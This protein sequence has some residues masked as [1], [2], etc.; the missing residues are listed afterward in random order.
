M[1]RKE[2]SRGLSPAW[3]PGTQV[4]NLRY[5]TLASPIVVNKKANPFVARWLCQVPRRTMKLTPFDKLRACPV[6]DTGANGKTET[7]QKGGWNAA[8][9]LVSRI[10][11]RK[12]TS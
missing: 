9:G 8:R 7:N 11:W 4:A 3:G 2:R 1:G 5:R 12:G 10:G 6:L